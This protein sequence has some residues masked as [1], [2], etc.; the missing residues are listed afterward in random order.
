MRAAT[1]AQLT[2][3]RFEYAQAIAG[4][5][6][7]VITT[8]VDNLIGSAIML[9]ENYRKMES[10][11]SQIAYLNSLSGRDLRVGQCAPYPL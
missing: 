6:M 11:L 9:L 5:D 1:L 8:A 10:R 2:R 4:T 7:D 3:L